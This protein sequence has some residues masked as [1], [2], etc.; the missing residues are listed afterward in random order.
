MS[1]NARRA[2]NS[3]EALIKLASALGSKRH[4][5]E[6]RSLTAELQSV[7]SLSL[8]EVFPTPTSELAVS[9]YALALEEAGTDEQKF[10]KVFELIE[11]D[12]F[13][14]AASLLALVKAY[15]GRTPQRGRT[16][17]L[18]AIRTEFNSKRQDAFKRQEILRLAGNR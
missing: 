15:S 4:L 10:N 18:Q 12:K 8:D 5:A 2:A 13:L 16:R 7:G 3:L 9:A 14:D 6:L 17:A 11:S 1:I